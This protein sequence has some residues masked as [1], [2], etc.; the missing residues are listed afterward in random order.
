MN[1]NHAWV[2]GITC[3]LPVGCAFEAKDEWIA[4]YPLPAAGEPIAAEFWDHAKNSKD[5]QGTDVSLWLLPMWA[6]VDHR[7]IENDPPRLSRTEYTMFNPGLALVP[8]LPFYIDAQVE[9]R[10][11]D[12]SWQGSGLTWTP[13]WAWSHS[14]EKA[15]AEL[16]AS[17]IPLLWGDVEVRSK[18]QP[19]EIRV[20]H[21]LWTLA[22]MVCS[23]EVGQDGADLDGYV[24]FPLY[25]AGLGGYLWGSI[26]L[27]GEA[28][29]LSGHG[30]FGGDLGYYRRVGLVKNRITTQSAEAEA[31]PI[32]FQLDL[33]TVVDESE[34]LDRMTRVDENGLVPSV[35]RWLGG[36]LWASWV[37]SDATG[38]E[39]DGRHGPLWTMFGYG[40]KNGESTV[41]LFWYPF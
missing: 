24:F 7:E 1:S 34:D 13:F 10:Q 38:K 23:I 16:R 14:T 20:R 11:Q 31:E 6:D 12:G 19:F 36:I 18:T 8:L 40:T 17:G 27:E 15:P 30:P 33:G 37:D 25:L 9:E 26:E 35:E 3:C 4:E 5:P 41:I 32:P 28:G 2:V 22:S 21:Y 39:V 29:S